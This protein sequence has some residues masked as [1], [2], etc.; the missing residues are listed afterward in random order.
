[1][2]LVVGEEGNIVANKDMAAMEK[3]ENIYDLY[4]SGRN[5]KI[6]DSMLDFQTDSGSVFFI[7]FNNVFLLYV[8]IQILKT[9]LLSFCFIFHFSIWFGTYNLNSI[10]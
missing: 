4:G 7:S 6:F 3:S 9:I 2:A 5:K 8:G 1:M 10:R